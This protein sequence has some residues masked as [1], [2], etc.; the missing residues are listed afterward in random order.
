MPLSGLGYICIPGALYVHARYRVIADASHVS[1]IYTGTR[2]R[3]AVGLSRGLSCGLLCL[4]AVGLFKDARSNCY[5]E[6][7]QGHHTIRG[8][9]PSSHCP[10]STANK[11]TCSHGTML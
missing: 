8:T 6:V 3:L 11:G 9:T 4:E 7:E 1:I 10:A 5:Q 2:S